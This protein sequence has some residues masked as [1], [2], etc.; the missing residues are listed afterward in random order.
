[1]PA[2]DVG[3]VRYGTGLSL[4]SVCLSVLA[5]QVLSIYMWLSNLLL[6]K[7]CAEATTTAAEQTTTVAEATTTVV[8]SVG[9]AKAE[10]RG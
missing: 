5:L 2:V 9:G 7:L 4:F 6:V 10:W 3:I 1:M 8:A